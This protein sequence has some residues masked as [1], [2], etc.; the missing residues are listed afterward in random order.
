LLYRH[1]SDIEAEQLAAI[2]ETSDAELAVFT[3]PARYLPPL[4]HLHL[5][6]HGETYAFSQFHG[7]ARIRCQGEIQTGDIFFAKKFE[8]LV[9]VEFH[10]RLD[11]LIDELLVKLDTRLNIAAVPYA[12]TGGMRLNCIAFEPC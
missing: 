12:K 11:Y 4:K 5:H 7:L 2:V 8:A 3:P 9:F 10:D 6:H 1:A